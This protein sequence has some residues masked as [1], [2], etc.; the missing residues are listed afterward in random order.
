MVMVFRWASARSAAAAVRSLISTDARAGSN[1]L[2]SPRDFASP[3]AWYEDRECSF[4][5]M[6]K[7][8]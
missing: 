8:W 5:V 2:A 6:H 1:C 3:V 7:V 4:S